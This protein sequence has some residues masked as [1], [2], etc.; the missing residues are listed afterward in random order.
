MAD[1]EDEKQIRELLLRSG[2]DAEA[3]LDEG[4]FALSTDDCVMDV[5]VGRGEDPYEIVRW[6]GWRRCANS[7]R[8][9]PRAMA[10]ASQG[11]A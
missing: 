7:C 3:C 10:T 2:Y 5:Q 9:A 6:E 4:H 8:C 11:V 1:L